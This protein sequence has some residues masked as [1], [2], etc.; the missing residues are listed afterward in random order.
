MLNTVSHA[1][2]RVEAALDETLMKLGVG[3]L[4]LYRTYMD[5]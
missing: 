1:A 3:Y 2:N 5:G 4:D